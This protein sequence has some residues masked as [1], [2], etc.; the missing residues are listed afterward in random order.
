MA[1]VFYLTTLAL[2]YVNILASFLTS[3]GGLVDKQLNPDV[4]CRPGG[5]KART[6]GGD[7]AGVTWSQE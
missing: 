1:S 6:E 4:S 5:E 3:G 7:T 2:K